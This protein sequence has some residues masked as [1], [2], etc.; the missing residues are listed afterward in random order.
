MGI[1]IKRLDDGRVTR[2]RSL[3]LSRLEPGLNF[4]GNVSLNELPIRN[5]VPPAHHSHRYRQVTRTAVV[6]R[7][8]K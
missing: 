8:H 5:Q 6:P 2:M 3:G 4:R 1:N 7:T